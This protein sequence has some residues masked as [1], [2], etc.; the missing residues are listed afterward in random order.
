MLQLYKE[1]SD[2]MEN[3]TITTT[4]NLVENVSNLYKYIKENNPTEEELINTFS[5]YDRIIIDFVDFYALSKDDVNTDNILL[6]LCET[7]NIQLIEIFKKEIKLGNLEE[8][9]SKID[10]KT[11]T[12]IYLTIYYKEELHQELYKYLK[13]LEEAIKKDENDDNQKDILEEWRSQKE[14]AD[15][16]IDALD[17][18]TK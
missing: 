10:W 4:K 8:Y 14:I 5:K 9:L 17:K 11:K 13:Q 15:R 12:E 18:I 7:L 2:S 6:N 3:I 16:K 1:K